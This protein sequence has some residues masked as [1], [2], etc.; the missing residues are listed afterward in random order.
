MLAGS[1][2]DQP[3]AR[4]VG[5]Y[6]SVSGLE[7]NVYSSSLDPTDAEYELNPV[8]IEF[9][10]SLIKEELPNAPENTSKRDI[11]KVLEDLS[12]GKER[13]IVNLVIDMSDVP[14]CLDADSQIIEYVEELCYAIGVTSMREGTDERD[15]EEIPV[16]VTDVGEHKFVEDEDGNV[17]GEEQV[18]G[19]DQAA[20]ITTIAHEVGFHAVSEYAD[21]EFSEINA[22]GYSEGDDDHELTAFFGLGGDPEEF[23]FEGAT[24]DPLDLKAEIRK[25]VEQGKLPPILIPKG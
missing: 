8:A 20:E 17:A 2:E 22:N 9:V 13:R 18:R 12:N 14:T 16:Q 3:N 6:E 4:F 1:P 24:G 25:L 21:G 5:S 11:L 15:A 10:I 19:S 7:F 23:D